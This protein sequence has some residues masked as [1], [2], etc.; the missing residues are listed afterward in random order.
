VQD[1][2]KAFHWFQMAAENGSAR[3]QYDLGQ[4]YEHGRGQ[5]KDFE[6]AAHWYGKSAA[7]G[8][9]RA[10]VKLD[11]LRQTGSFEHTDETLSPSP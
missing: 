1:D 10:R 4:I 8:V 9:E 11:R 2:S 3:G 7:Q 5:P 6:L